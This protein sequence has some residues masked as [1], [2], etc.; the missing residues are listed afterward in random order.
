MMLAM[1]GSMESR[2]VKYALGSGQS[3]GVAL[4]VAPFRLV[5]VVSAAQTVR[6][7]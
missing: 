4:D 3:C 7:G 1:L 6:I 5:P 2:Y